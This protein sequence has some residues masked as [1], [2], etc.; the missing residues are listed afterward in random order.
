MAVTIRLAR[1]GAKKHAYYRVVVADSRRSR[2]GKFLEWVGTYNPAQDPP[3]VELEMPRIE[4]WLKNG[5]T[6]SLTVKE[7]IKAARKAGLAPAAAP[8]AAPAKKK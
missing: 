4:E 3:L 7:L 2:N 8:A 1:K 6:T 5:A